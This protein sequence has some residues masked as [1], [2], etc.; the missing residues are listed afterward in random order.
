[1]RCIPWACLLAVVPLG[2][3][4]RADG[5][6]DGDDACRGEARDEGGAG[7]VAGVGEGAAGLA[8]LACGVLMSMNL[9]PDRKSVV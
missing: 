4:P 3:L 7:G 1:M 2:C 8:R 9:S 6:A 5:D